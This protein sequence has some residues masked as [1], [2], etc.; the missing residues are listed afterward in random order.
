MILHTG[1]RTD[2]PAF[3][4][5]WFSQRLK[6]GYVLVRNPYNP[7]SVTRYEINPGV[8]DL[9]VFCTKNPAPMFS[10]MDL[11]KPYK[12]F[13]FVTITPYGKEIEPLV[14]DKAKSVNDFKRLSTIVGK[15]AAV[16]RYDP[17]FINDTYTLNRHIEC[18]EAMARELHGYT[19]TCVI[20]FIDLYRKV[21]RNFPHVKEVSPADR[22]AIGKAF[23]S[24]GKKYDITI[25]TC[26]EGE[27]LSPFGVDCS[28]CMTSSVFED[29]IG[30]PLKIPKGYKPSRNECSCIL[31]N[32]IGQYDTC[33]H[34]CRYCYANSNTELVKRNMRLHD[35]DSPFLIGHSMP[36]D[37]INQAHQESWLDMQLR[38]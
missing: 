27:D 13:W 29:I 10:Y 6:A 12:H 9:I 2:I 18:F 14:P 1:N 30:C 35:P 38:F 17:I 24:I 25:K 15:S 28:G 31:S 34:L 8:V 21:K 36:E 5:K 11:L 22:V 7:I 32:D 26:A 3:Y 23:V 20:S 33:G 37:I 19:K 4:S 16:W